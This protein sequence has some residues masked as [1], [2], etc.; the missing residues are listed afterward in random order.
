MAGLN[1]F[2]NNAATTLATGINSSVTSLTVA[3]AT[4]A[5]F[6]TLA[7]SQYFYCT[8]SNTAGT[9]IEIVKVTARST[10]TFT[11]VR[12]QDNTTAAAFIAGDKVELR[13]TAAD[14]QNFPQLDSTNTFALAQTF[15][16][17]IA[18]TSG[19]TG[20]TTSTGSGSNVLSTSPTLVTP[21]LGTPTS[22]VATNLTGL[23]LTTGV[24][25]TLPI[26]NGGT[27]ST[28]AAGANANLQTYT[29]TATAAGT[30]TLTNTSTYYQYFT[31]T[32]TQTV[33]LPVTSTLSL[34]WSF[35]IANNSTGN[36]TLQSSGL[37]TIA[38]ILP[39]TT[40]HVTCILTSGTTAASWDY[41]FTDFN[42]S[43][44]VA[45]G[46]TGNT[47]ATAYA[48]LAGGTTTTGA[49]QSLA[50]VGT[51]GQI[52]TSNGAG[53]LPTFQ[54]AAGG[55]GF[56]GI[57]VFTSSGTFT[58]PSGKTTIK[59]TIIGAG[60]GSCAGGS[61]GGAGGSSSL[62][63]GTQ[64]ITTL[65]A[66]GGTGGPTSGASGTNGTASGAS[67]ISNY[68]NTNIGFAGYTYTCGTT[69]YVAFS[70]SNYNVMGLS[71]TNST[72]PGAGGEAVYIGGG[73]L[74]SYGGAG[75]GGIW[76]LTGLTSGNTLTVTIGQGGTRGSNVGSGYG[77]TGY[78]GAVVIEY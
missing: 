19:G 12:G 74:F 46:G 72:T 65:T 64:T 58:I 55:G 38:T 52:L 17:A 60:G 30:T 39:N 16:T 62:S 21:I 6:P 15:T 4:G 70:Y 2:T 76:Y 53:A 25:G 49:F 13:L 34:G 43:V 59:V 8:L 1:L 5:L 41:G 31:G 36:L 20:V 68:L 71:I 48:L 56:T 37:N 66:T 73:T 50:S 57:Q 40:A 54:T 45:L 14:L 11:I 61:A 47:S 75:G 29:T 78:N 35:H 51:T 32:T 69:G 3:S 33:V 26:A 24:T 7:G 27:N 67:L 77:N 10:D 23:P 28:T 22:G 42:T 18:V 44:P 63:S 9:T